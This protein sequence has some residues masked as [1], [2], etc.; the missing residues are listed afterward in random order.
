MKIIP[1]THSI[2]SVMV[3]TCPYCKHITEDTAYGDFAGKVCQ[4]PTCKGT[5]RVISDKEVVAWNDP[6]NL[7]AIEGE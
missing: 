1:V 6:Y 2:K 5:I 3:W 4:C 7:K